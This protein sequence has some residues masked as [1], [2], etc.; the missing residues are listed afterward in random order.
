[1]TEAI[2]KV[3]VAPAKQG[4]AERLLALYA[5][6]LYVPGTEVAA[7]AETEKLTFGMINETAR[8]LKNPEATP[9]AEVVQKWWLHQVKEARGEEEAKEVERAWAD[10]F[11]KAK[12]EAE[13]DFKAKLSGCE[14]EGCGSEAGEAQACGGAGTETGGGVARSAAPSRWG[15]RTRTLDLPPRPSRPC[16]PIHLRHRAISRSLAG[17]GWRTV[18]LGK[19][20]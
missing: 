19:R 12:A 3:E 20:Y 1:M 9:W 18:R 8:W 17:L 4:E 16:R 10:A 11:E 6:A 14:R 15:D 5:K 2:N 7:T 13:P